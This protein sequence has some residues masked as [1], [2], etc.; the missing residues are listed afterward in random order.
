MDDRREAQPGKILHEMRFSEL[1][2]AGEVP[3]AS[4]YGTVDATPLFV[5]LA[6]EYMLATGDRELLEEIWENLLKADEW[7]DRYGDLDGDGFVEYDRKDKQG[8]LNQGW[9]DSHD[10]HWDW[11]GTSNRVECFLRMPAILSWLESCHRRKPVE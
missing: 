4:Y 3:F 5:I 7:I 11:T 2:R 10:W 9:K 1:A 6:G 8:L